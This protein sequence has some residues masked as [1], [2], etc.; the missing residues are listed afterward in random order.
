MHIKHFCINVGSC[1]PRQSLEGVGINISGVKCCQLN[2]WLICLVFVKILITT[3]PAKFGK[4]LEKC[5][6]I[7]VTEGLCYF[8]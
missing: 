1:C 3:S 5:N 2:G 6:K 4:S 7:I 8:M